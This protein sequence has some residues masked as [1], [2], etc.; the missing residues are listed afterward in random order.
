MTEQELAEE[1]GYRVT[2]RLGIMCGDRNPTKAQVE[3]AIKEA[4]EACER[5]RNEPA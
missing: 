3:L 4:D 2:E 1:H 5:L